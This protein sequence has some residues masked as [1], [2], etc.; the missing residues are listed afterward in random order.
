MRADFQ[1]APSQEV[2]SS[3]REAIERSSLVIGDATGR[4]ANV[5]L[6]LGFAQAMGKPI[7]L[8][9][10]DPGEIPF[11]LA[12]VRAIT[13]QPGAPIASLVARLA[14]AII[15]TASA[16]SS[17]SSQG[18]G[19][20][21]GGGASR[22][23]VFFSYSHADAEYLDRMMVHLR[24]VERS[25]A[26]N[27]WSDTKIRAGDRWKEEIRKA[28]D[29]ARV[30][31]LLISADFLASDFIATD[32]LPPLLAAAELEGARIIPVVVKPSRFLRDDSLARFQALNNPRLHIIR[33]GEA[34]REE[35]YA[36]L[37]EVVEAELG[38]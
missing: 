28:L 33:M 12:S 26:V 15:A 10:E 8:I 3:I 20:P 36:K 38:L 14:D 7:L 32:E 17:T 27:L 22:D 29:K 4:N 37:A 18:N 23:Q 1:F 21:D 24:P 34:D 30:A 31:V 13:Y 25:G 35:L 19:S 5:M 11:D 9:T 6:E 2:T 16:S